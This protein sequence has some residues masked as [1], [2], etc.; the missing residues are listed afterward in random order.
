[1]ASK[2][3]MKVYAGSESK[4]RVENLLGAAGIITVILGVLLFFGGMIEATIEA[5]L[6]WF[7]CAL[8]FLIGGI[9]MAWT[10]AALA[11]GIRLLKRLNGLPYGGAISGIPST[12]IIICASCG[13]ELRRVRKDFDRHMQD[14]DKLKNC[15]VCNEEIEK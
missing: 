12:N 13:H 11:E 6:T 3:W 2:L 8:L 15:P 4:T 14:L 9:I 1:M 10:F 5:S 7:L